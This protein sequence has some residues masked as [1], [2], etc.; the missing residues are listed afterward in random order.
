MAPL[1]QHCGQEFDVGHLDQH[2]ETCTWTG[3]AGEFSC[4][5]KIR[6]SDHCYSYE[7][8]GSEQPENAH[9]F[10]DRNGQRRVFCPTR[11]IHSCELPEILRGLCAKPTHPVALTPER[12]W[13]IFR[14]MMP[15]PLDTDEK[16]WIFFRLRLLVGNLKK[17]EEVDL[18]VESAYPR[19][20]RPVLTGQRSMFG[21]ALEQL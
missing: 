8:D 18:F 3:A 14:L 10:N 16:F 7:D 1:I 5:V 2:I 19:K 15:S 17:P 11:H 12:N 9:I 4:L 21:R 13:T 6:Y 20:D